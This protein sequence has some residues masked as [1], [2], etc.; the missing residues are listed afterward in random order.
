MEDEPAMVVGPDGALA[1]ETVCC[2]VIVDHVPVSA[3]VTIPASFAEPSVT[4]FWKVNP[5][6]SLFAS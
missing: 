4:F 5:R 2:V 6:R 3:A 1:T